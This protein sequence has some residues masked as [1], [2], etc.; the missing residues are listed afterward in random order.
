M[1]REKVLLKDEKSFDIITLI[2]VLQGG[3]HMNYAVVSEK[4]KLLKQVQDLGDSANNTVGFLSR[5]AFADY[6]RKGHI[7]ALIEDDNL[8]AYIMYRYK[9]SAIVIVQLCVSPLHQGKGLAKLLVN[10]LFEREKDCIS[11][12]QL[13]CRRD[14]NLENFWV[15][16]GFTPIDERAGRATTRDT[17]LTT[18]IRR[19]TECKDIFA[20]LSEVDKQRTQ[21]VIDT[22]IV[23]DLYNG[24]NN[25]SQTL[26]QS[27]LAD[28][29]EFRISKYVL[30]EIN[31]NDDPNSRKSHRDYAKTQFSLTEATDNHMF[32]TVR[33]DL[34]QRKPSPEFSNTWFD[35]CHIADAI[36]CGAEVFVTRDAAWL[37]TDIARYIF[38]QYNL[39]IM[40]PG[41]FV[42]AVDE[43]TSPSDYAPIKLAGLN[44]DFLKMQH[45]D[46]PTVL[47]VFFNK[48]GDKKAEFDQALR[49]WMASPDKYSILLVKSDEN[50]LCFAVATKTEKILRVNA[51]LVNSSAIRPSLLDTFIKRVAFKILDNAKKNSVE[52]IEIS[53]EKVSDD[54]VESLMACGFIDN[55]TVLLRIID[56]RVIT[57]TQICPIPQLRANN[58]LQ[59]TIARYQED[60][61]AGKNCADL[62]FGL[63]K[64]QWPLKISPSDIPCYIVPIK[65]EYAVQLFDEN[66]ANDHLSLFANTK[67]EPALSI[68]NAYFKSK[69][70]SV[71]N[72]PA[73]ILWYVSQSEYMQT[74]AI[75]ACSY[76]DKV[77]TDTKKALFKKYHRL[78]VL[79]WAELLTIGG[80]SDLITAYIFSYTELFDYPIALAQARNYVNCPAETFQ[81]YKKIDEP[82]FMQIYEAGVYGGNH[83]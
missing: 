11:H 3:L 45:S 48:F 74:G 51:L 18:W 81:S 44:F 47:D 82:V 10:E 5:E 20:L 36:A 28:Y 6:A 49:S 4:S 50:P 40:S 71:P 52:Q 22:N 75:R 73:R 63:E 12:M 33:G 64:A 55:G 83:V 46:Y 65:A 19:N 2:N 69:R 31:R 35:I 60:R 59:L 53:K 26:T 14:Y 62:V 57:P 8:L 78:G 30:D 7:L 37:N 68:E 70:H 56:S 17:V 80:K 32:E 9:K 61:E 24:G 43:L 38:A 79:D 66:L 54:T 42:N 77:E 16:L 29:A 39:D 67:T 15:S 25:E 27:F 58:P 21:V 23:I 1:I 76:L 13:S 41:A 72:G 34:L